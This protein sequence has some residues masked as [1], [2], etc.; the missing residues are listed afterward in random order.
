MKRYIRTIRSAIN[1]LILKSTGRVSHREVGVICAN[2]WYGN[3]YGGFY[4]C[5]HLLNE[6][7]IVYSFGIGEYISFDMDICKYHNCNVYGFDPTPKSIRWVKGSNPPAKFHF[8]DYGIGSKTG[9]VD[10]YLPINPKHVSG[11]VLIQSNVDL[12]EKVTVQMKSISD[13]A[14]ELGHTHIDVLKMDI[15]GAEYDVIEDILTSGISIDQILIEFHDRFVEN[16]RAKTKKAVN[17]LKDHG[18]EI[19]AVSD[20]FEEVSFVNTR[21]LHQAQLA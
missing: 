9:P 14:S 12:K 19:F 1:H 21:I 17:S 20:S 5:C 3:T 18:F 15:E 13:I 10:F 2:A 6:S 4:V 16:G 8:S 11:S 7:S